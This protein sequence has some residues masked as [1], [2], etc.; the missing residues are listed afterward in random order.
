MITIFPKNTP[1]TDRSES[2]WAHNSYFPFPHSTRLFLTVPDRRKCFNRCLIYRSSWSS[3]SALL[4]YTIPCFILNV[5]LLIQAI[6]SGFT[7]LGCVWPSR[8]WPPARGRPG[9]RAWSGLWC[10][11]RACWGRAWRR[12][13][14]VPLPADGTRSSSLRMRRNR[15]VK[16][17]RPAFTLNKI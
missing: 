1:Q 6:Q 8:W 15:D 11:S 16:S 4:T 10:R 17:L 13:S 14:P 7:D 5:A 3:C 9:H 12:S 2:G